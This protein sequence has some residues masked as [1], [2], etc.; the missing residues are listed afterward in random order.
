[1]AMDPGRLRPGGKIHVAGQNQTPRNTRKT[2]MAM[3]RG[4][5]RHEGGIPVAG[6]NL[7]PTKTRKA[8]MALRPGGEIPGV[9]PRDRDREGL[10]WCAVLC[11]GMVCCD[12]ADNVQTSRRL[13]GIVQFVSPTRW[14]LQESRITFEN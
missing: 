5:L 8:A 12:I 14:L 11:C 13:G 2:A 4:R 3:D 9:D 10:V 1:M 7:M 6:Q